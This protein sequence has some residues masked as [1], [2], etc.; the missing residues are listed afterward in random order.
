MVKRLLPF[1]VLALTVALFISA[2]AL[3]EKAEKAAANHTGTVVSFDGKK[4]VMKDQ[5][6]KEQT[7]NISDNTI[8]VLDGKKTD[9]S[10]FKTLKEGA[11]VRVWCDKDNKDQATKIEALDKETDF[12]KQ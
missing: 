10:T 5:N 11:K 7:L 2:P 6:A 8:L 12:P 3:A 9:V 1:V 4:L